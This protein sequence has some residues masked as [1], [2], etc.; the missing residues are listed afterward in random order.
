MSD[1][2]KLCIKIIIVRK[3]VIMNTYKKEFKVCLLMLIVSLLV[4]L[5]VNFYY[6]GQRENILKKNDEA[7]AK[8]EELSI[9]LDK[10]NE[11]SAIL[12]SELINANNKIDILEEEINKLMQ[13]IEELQ[14]KLPVSLGK[15]KLTAYC[16]CSKCCGKWANGVTATGVMPKEGRTIAVD[17]NVIP[18]GSKVIID[19][20]EYI[21]EDVGGAIKGNR[22]DVYFDSHKDALN[23][24]VKHKEVF[25]VKK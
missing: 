9:E 11:E 21:A 22:I 18:L 17:R 8:V 4:L 14:K 15:F 2:L 5:I 19:G 25:I 24:G 7:N 3:V 20:K 10:A 23:F 16:N 6:E 1:G 12:S 13:N